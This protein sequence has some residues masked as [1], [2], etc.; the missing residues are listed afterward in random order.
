MVGQ[1]GPY[2]VATESIYEHIRACEFIIK[3]II[4]RYTYLYYTHTT[5][6]RT[7]TYKY[8][9]YLRVLVYYITYTEAFHGLRHRRE[10]IKNDKTCYYGISLLTTN[11]ITYLLWSTKSEK[12]VCR[13]PLFTS[14]TLHEFL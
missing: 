1:V 4:I 5:H 9:I 6:T 3:K 13:S 8:I 11:V 12:P 2:L 10:A 7:L 14:Q